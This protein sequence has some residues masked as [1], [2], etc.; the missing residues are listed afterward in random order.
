MSTP[1]RG[2]RIPLE[3]GRPDPAAL[4][5]AAAAVRS[6]GVVA[7]PTET[8]YALGA[9]P[10]SPEALN[11][12][13]EIKGRDPGKP[14]SVLI[15]RVDRLDRWARDIGEEGRTL[16]RV[17]WPGPLTL[18]FNPAPGVQP[19]LIGKSGRIGLRLPGHAVARG[20]AGALDGAITGTSANRSGEKSLSTADEVERV[21]GD[22][23]DLILDGGVTPGGLESTVVDAVLHPPRLIREGP[24]AFRAVLKAV[25]L[26]PTENHE[27]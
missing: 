9:N 24:I 26:S 8:Y 4:R 6:G 15:D 11:R 13:F 23:L 7:F 16:I 18:L 20:L 19:A 12:I 10:R 27:W 3:P 2:K 1:D 17:F 21:L 14:L 5:E 22:R 25:G